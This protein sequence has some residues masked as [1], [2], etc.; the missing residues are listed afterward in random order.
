LVV[1]VHW[2]GEGCQR[3]DSQK[4]KAVDHGVTHIVGVNSSE[5]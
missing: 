5:F 3:R 1:G 4:K 2:E